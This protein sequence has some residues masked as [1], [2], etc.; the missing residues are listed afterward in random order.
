MAFRADKSFL[1]VNWQRFVKTHSSLIKVRLI[2]NSKHE[3]KFENGLFIISALEGTNLLKSQPMSKRDASK[4]KR[5]TKFPFSIF[6]KTKVFFY[7]MISYSFNDLKI[8]KVKFFRFIIR[9]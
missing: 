9:K 3:I 4:I 8:I 5:T 1:F 6:S 7:S 2:L